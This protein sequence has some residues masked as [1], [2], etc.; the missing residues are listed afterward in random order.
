MAEDKTRYYLEYNKDNI[1]K[2]LIQAEVHYRNLK[3]GYQFTNEEVTGFANCIVKHLLDAEGEADEAV[4]HSLMVEGSEPSEKFKR[5]RDELRA[6]RKRVQKGQVNVD[7]GIKEV[8]RLRREFELFNP[9]YDISRCKSCGPIEEWLGL[10]KTKPLEELERETADKV[11][12]YLSQKYKVPKPELVI[13]ERCT[14]PSFGLYEKGKIA[15]CK[16]GVNIH[17]LAHEFKHYMDHLQG[18]PISEVEAERFAV[19]EMVEK[20]HFVEV[21]AKYSERISDSAVWGI[22]LF[23]LGLNVALTWYKCAK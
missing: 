12:T 16:G 14:E 10:L 1:A 8:R 17:V 23:G 6:F 4:S 22:L 11:L 18:K 20:S 5:L 19:Q 7:E 3:G 15:M 13:T 9:E 21:E 2:N